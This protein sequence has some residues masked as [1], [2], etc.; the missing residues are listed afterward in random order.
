VDT[1]FAPFETPDGISGN[2]LPV[3]ESSVTLLVKAIAIEDGLGK[4]L[5]LKI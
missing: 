3:W 1:K 2:V 5:L 4:E